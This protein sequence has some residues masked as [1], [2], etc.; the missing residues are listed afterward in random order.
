[1]TTDVGEVGARACLMRLRLCRMRSTCSLETQSYVQVEVP[2]ADI[3]T[4]AV[5]EQDDGEGKG[6]GEGDGHLKADLSQR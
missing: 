5:V 3:E 1:M 6:E 4:Y 2:S